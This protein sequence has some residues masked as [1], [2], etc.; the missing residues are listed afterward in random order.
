MLPHRAS[1]VF[2]HTCT[3]NA[4]VA[5]AVLCCLQAELSAS[6]KSLGMQ[7]A[8]MRKMSEQLLK[9]GEA[10]IALKAELA[11]EQGLVKSL[12]EK[13]SKV[14]HNSAHDRPSPCSSIGWRN[15]TRSHA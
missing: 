4:A 14:G 5:L 13:L 6:R 1:D 15:T 8:M 9:E 11:K 2:Q 12:R 3:D 7:E 10:V